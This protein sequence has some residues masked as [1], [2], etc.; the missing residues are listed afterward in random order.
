LPKS[1]PRAITGLENTTVMAEFAASSKVV[2]IGAVGFP[3]SKSE[4][5]M[6][7][8]RRG[9]SGTRLTWP[10]TLERLQMTKKRARLAARTRL[11]QPEPF[12]SNTISTNY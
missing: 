9:S 6:D 7:T 12:F 10:A 2:L 11:H 3:A 8:T 1:D 5:V 4:G